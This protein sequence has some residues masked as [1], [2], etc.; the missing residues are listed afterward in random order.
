MNKEEI[1]AQVAEI[2]E[3]ISNHSLKYVLKDMVRCELDPDDVEY[4]THEYDLSEEALEALKLLEFSDAGTER[5]YS[6]YFW[7][8]KLRGILFQ[9]DGW[10]G[11]W[12]GAEMDGF[13]PYPV[14][15]VKKMVEITEYI[16]IK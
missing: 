12:S 3:I 9:V 4:L 7:R 11:S 14:E 2:N 16:P 6:N 8:F 10:Y 13:D 5:D 15:E 1:L